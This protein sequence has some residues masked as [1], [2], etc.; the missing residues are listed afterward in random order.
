MMRWIYAVCET[1][2]MSISMADIRD[3]DEYEVGT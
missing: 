1:T 2:G 3:R